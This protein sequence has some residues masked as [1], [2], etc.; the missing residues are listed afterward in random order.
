MPFSVAS[1]ERIKEWLL[2]NMTG[3]ERLRAGMP[4][5]WKVGDKTGTSTNGVTNDIGVV[6]PPNRAPIIVSAYLAELPAS[7]DERN[8]ILKEIGHIVATSMPS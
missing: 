6:W 8:V 4:E 3:D 2:A 5:D 7:S 1:R